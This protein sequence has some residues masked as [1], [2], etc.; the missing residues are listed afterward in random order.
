MMIEI[1]NK[2][3]GVRELPIGILLIIY[4][5]VREEESEKAV[6]YLTL[7][8]EYKPRMQEVMDE[9]WKY[10]DAIANRV[11]ELLIGD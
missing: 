6:Q 4:K 5:S 9:L 1:K 2:P 10:R 3:K 11:C 7:A 8:E